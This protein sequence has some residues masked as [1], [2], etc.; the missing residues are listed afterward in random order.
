V[1]DTIRVAGPV[2]VRST[3]RSWRA[4]SVLAAVALVFGGVVL[5]RASDPTTYDKSQVVTNINDGSAVIDGV[6]ATL[7]RTVG[8]GQQAQI[9][10][11]ALIR[12]IVCPILAALATGPFGGFI[13]PIIN[14]LR[15][16]FGCIS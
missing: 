3:R 8:F 15:A 11:G 1:E 6:G 2:E 4:V 12:S 13:G 9:D 5:A 7:G 10:V 14:S 16:A